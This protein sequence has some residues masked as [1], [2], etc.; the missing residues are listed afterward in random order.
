MERLAGKCC[1]PEEGEEWGFLFVL[2][3][4]PGEYSL[5]HLTGCDFRPSEKCSA[6]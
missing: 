5:R 2:I 4:E 1:S 3:M 6:L